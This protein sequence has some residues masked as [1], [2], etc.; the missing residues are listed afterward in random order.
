MLGQARMQPRVTVVTV[1]P[2]RKCT[3]LTHL[4]GDCCRRLLQA[5]ALP[6]RVGAWAVVEGWA[7]VLLVEGA[8]W[9]RARWISLHAAACPPPL[10]DAPAAPPPAKAKG[11]SCEEAHC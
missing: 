6:V 11:N 3:V 4:R 9:A 2:M 8:A 7:W 5:L 10:P 1:G